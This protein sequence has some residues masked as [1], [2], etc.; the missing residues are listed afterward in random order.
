MPITNRKIKTSHGDIAVCQT[1]G[2]ELPIVFI[3]GNS[4]RKE[5]FRKQY[6]SPLGERHRMIAIDLPGHGVSDDA[7]AP[8]KSYTITGYAD[9]VVEVLGALDVE[10]AAIVGWS[11]GGHV[12]LEMIPR[13]DGMA[14]A[15]IV[16]APPVGRSPEEIQAG[17]RPTPNIMLAGKAEFTPEEIDLFAA[18]T[19][20]TPVDPMLRAAIARTDGR[21]RAIMF[22]S[23]FRGEVSDERKLVEETPVPIAVVNGSDDPLV[24]VDYVGAV[25]YRNLWDD[26]CYLLRGAGHACFLHEPAAFN[27]ILARFATDMA[28]RTERRPAGKSRVVAA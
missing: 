16:A 25:A 15:M 9:A 22:A 17:F 27:A 13:Y 7:L 18:A 6:E 5:A 1:S 24:N 20:G 3:H 10:R 12:A 19:C 28:V 21:A 26:H 11:L 23:L 2:K 8:E 4:S 14:G